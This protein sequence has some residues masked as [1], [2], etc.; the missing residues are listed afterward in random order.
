MTRVM[1][2]QVGERIILKRVLKKLYVGSGVNLRVSDLHPGWRSCAH[3]Y[4][5]A[6]CIKHGRICFSLSQILDCRRT[7]LLLIDNTD[8]Q[9]RVL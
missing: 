3:N 6:G 4:E 7:T 8:L 2:T 5:P 9:V 1:C